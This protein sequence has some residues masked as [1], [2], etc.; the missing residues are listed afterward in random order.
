MIKALQSVPHTYSIDVDKASENCL[1]GLPKHYYIHQSWLWRKL[2]PTK[3]W[4]G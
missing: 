4:R 3:N 1:C 2:H